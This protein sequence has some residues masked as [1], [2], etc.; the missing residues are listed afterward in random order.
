MANTA[1]FTTVFSCLLF[2][3]GFLFGKTSPQPIK[4]TNPGASSSPGTVS[5]T[6]S[7]QY[8]EDVFIKERQLLQDYI[9][10]LEQRLSRKDQVLEAKLNQTLDEI[11]NITQT[12]NSEKAQRVQLQK[13]YDK[14]IVDFYDLTVD[15]VALKAK[16]KALEVNNT[17]QN[18]KIILLN[19]TLHNLT[20]SVEQINV[21]ALM[22]N[23]TDVLALNHK[24]GNL[25]P[26][27]VYLTFFPF[28]G[29]C[30]QMLQKIVNLT[31]TGTAPV[32]RR[33]NQ[34]QI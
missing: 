12:L 6:N 11:S 5:P 18:N 29:G 1:V 16:N 32:I 4:T 30:F 24:A 7:Y 34:Y 25:F 19:E 33:G 28:P 9:M 20:E 26:F 15:Q 10:I 27:H 31:F 21:T 13:D 8:L 23:H 22:S 17:K 2:C 3:D 14:L